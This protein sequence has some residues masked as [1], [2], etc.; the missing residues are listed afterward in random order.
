LSSSRH[1]Q[2]TMSRRSRYQLSMRYNKILLVTYAAT[3]AVVMLGT[4]SSKYKRD[5]MMIFMIAMMI[6]TMVR[7]AGVG[8]H[9]RFLDVLLTCA[10]GVML[11]GHKLD[12][13]DMLGF[14]MVVTIGFLTMCVGGPGAWIS[15]GVVLIPSLLQMWEKWECQKG[16]WFEI[17]LGFCL[18][19]MLISIALPDNDHCELMFLFFSFLTKAMIVVFITV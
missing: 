18:F 11:M 8:R 7:L 3:L 6:M 15:G 10:L 16:Y 12:V 13:A 19:M 2:R 5:L 17:M 9:L 4:S 14:F 1:M